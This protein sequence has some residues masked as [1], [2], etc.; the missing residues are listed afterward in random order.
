MH[1]ATAAATNPL[2]PEPSA[3]A[4][5]RLLNDFLPKAADYGAE[6]N[7]DRPGHANVSRLSPYLARR[8]ISERSVCEA[9]RERYRLPQ[10]E[11]FVQEIFW[12]TY[13]KGWLEQRPSVWHDYR[14]SLAA[15]GMDGAG[16]KPVQRKLLE[17][18]CNGQTGIACFD[19]WAR[20]LV[21]SHYLHNHARMWFASIWLFT[22]RLPWELGADFF[23]R[24]L[25]DADPA[26]NTLSWRWVA[27]L[28]TPGKHYL[29]RAENIA[30]F[31]EGRFNP[32]AQLNESADP[33]PMPNSDPRPH[34]DLP[35]DSI[36]EINTTG[37]GLLLLGDDLS[38]QTGPLGEHRWQSVAGGW[39][40]SIGIEYGIAP[41]VEAFSKQAIELAVA[42]VAEHF[43]APAQ[44]FDSGNWCQGVLDWVQ[45]NELS[46]VVVSYPS[47]GPWA[48]RLRQLR[49]LA[50]ASLVIKTLVRP[51]DRDLWP[52]AKAGFFKFK[53]VIP[54]YWDSL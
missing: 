14:L 35:D 37:V 3:E 27:G 25:L 11:K 2:L 44:L 40:E 28:Q 41:G 20:E 23:Y 5:W 17:Q 7:F 1:N 6:R 53:Q 10:V 31:T 43:Q 51:W 26:S 24:H 46:A 22:L 8:I 29:A 45:S 48:D 42:R 12:R 34:M 16:L 39:D 52:L 49:E 47:V 36:E 18:A 4:A 19:H 38:P 33:L 13:W 32:V 30:R 50:P 21:Q 54:R 9:L 15:L